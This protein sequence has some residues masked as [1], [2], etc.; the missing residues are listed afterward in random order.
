MR[1][2][3]FGRFAAVAAAVT[4]AGG[5]AAAQDE[6]PSTIAV[7]TYSTTAAG[8]AQM[9]AV[10]SALQEEHGV[11]LRP[12]PGDN[13]ISRQAPLKQGQAQFSSTGFGVFYSQE[14]IFEFADRAQWGPQPVRLVMSNVSDGGIGFAIDPALGIDHPSEMEGVR[15]ARIVGAPA[16]N[17]LV[18]AYLTFGGLTW[19]DV[20]V[21]E[22]PGFG[23]WLDGYVNDQV[24]AGIAVTDSGTS[25]KLA[26]SSRGVTWVLFPQDDAEGWARLNAFAPWFEP[27]TVTSGNEVPQEGL[28]FA[29][30]RY[31]NLVTYADVDADTVYGFTK[32]MVELYPEYS[33]EAPGAYGWAVERQG[34]E[35]VM[36]FHEGAIRYWKE[37]GEWTDAAQA[38][39][40]ELLERQRVLQQTWE[41]VVARDIA[42]D[43]AFVEAWAEARH[44]ALTEA[45]FNPYFES[46]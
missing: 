38:R 19:D 4:L 14:G 21:V 8:F 15:V 12:I 22:F 23:A 28:P 2:A 17:L 32:A 41:E 43:A 20:E 24:D 10:G 5:T 40:E 27:K 44:A 9:V 6:L 46:W 11:N 7:T 13:D 31:P 35:Y 30:Y 45:G 37:I 29:V 16:L 34:F 3:L 18:E 42:D 33:D 36:P 1:H 26:A 25:G 39:Q